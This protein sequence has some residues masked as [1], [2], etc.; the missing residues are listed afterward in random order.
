MVVP[1]PRRQTSGR[2]YIYLRVGDQKVSVTE[3]SEK[4]CIRAARL[5]KAEILAG[6]RF[7][8]PEKIILSLVIDKYISS[9]TRV[10]S[11]STIRGYR[12]I[13]ASR[14]LDAQ[15]Q[16]L[17]ALDWQRVVNDEASLCS[18]KT[19]KNAWGLVSAA[20]LAETGQRPHVSLPQVVRSEHPFLSPDQIQQ[21]CAAVRG[22][23]VEIPALLGLCS[24]RCSEILGLQWQ[25]IDLAAGVIRVRGSMVRDE[26]GVMVRKQTNKNTTS[27]RD[28][29]VLMPQLLE[30]LKAAPPH[31][32][33]DPV[34]TY[35][36]RGL[37]ARVN[38]VCRHA[39]LPEVGMHGLRHSFAS[40]AY[41]LNIPYKVTMQIAGWADDATMRRIYT[42][43]AQSSITDAASSLT[44]FF[45]PQEPTT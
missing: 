17:E 37:L 39:G 18:P 11:P 3:N 36:A 44:A 22:D 26:R 45:S 6:K 31:K 33:E 40:L 10:L 27:N 38:T 43:V 13:Q 28:V 23:P 1:K 16:P 19:L 7:Y 34:V 9:R 4:A 21:F 2:W 14:F 35:T 12:M 30:A 25:H 24:L 29:P 32:P 41:H 15:K 8:P 5:I 20:V 42:H